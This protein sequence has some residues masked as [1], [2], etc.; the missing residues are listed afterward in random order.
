M[1]YIF[2]LYVYKTLGDDDKVSNEGGRSTADR[3]EIRAYSNCPSLTAWAA[4]TIT[5]ASG[6]LHGSGKLVLTFPQFLNGRDGEL[7]CPFDITSIEWGDI[8]PRGRSVQL[9]AEPGW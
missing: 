8:D 3:A 4:G 7:V 6:I 9:S 5:I 2:V 1:N